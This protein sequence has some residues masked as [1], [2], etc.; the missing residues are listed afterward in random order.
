MANRGVIANQVFIGL[1]WTARKR[2]DHAVDYLRTRSPLSF[3]IVGRNDKT[4]R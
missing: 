4:R 1:P 2:Y 3:I